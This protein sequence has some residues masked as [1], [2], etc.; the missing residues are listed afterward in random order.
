ML[1]H[2]L[3]TKVFFLDWLYFLVLDNK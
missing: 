3:E 2:G 1:F